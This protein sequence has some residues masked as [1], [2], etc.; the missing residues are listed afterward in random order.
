M[1]FY[2]YVLTGMVRFLELVR[3]PEMSLQKMAFS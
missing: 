2:E 1:L 3:Q